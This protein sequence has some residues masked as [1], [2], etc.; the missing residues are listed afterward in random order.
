MFTR[1]KQLVLLGLLLTVMTLWACG[2][3]RD[4]ERPL[5]VTTTTYVGD[6]VRQIGGPYIEVIT[7]IGPG[8]DPHDYQPRQS[9]TKWL[10][11]ADLVV[12]NGLNLEERFGEVL[13]NLDSRSLLV[14]GDHV[15]T[16]QLLFE[17]PNV[18]DPH[19][20]FDPAIWMALAPVVRDALIAIDPANQAAYTARTLQYQRDIEVFVHYAMQQVETVPS[21]RRILVTAH[22]AFAYFGRAFGFE[23]YAVQGIS[24]SGEASIVD[25]EN[26]ARLL[27]ELDIPAL[28]VET[29]VPEATIQAVVE[30]AAALN[31]TV[32]VGGTLYSDSAGVI[33]SGTDTYLRAYRH[34][35]TTIIQA[36]Q[37][38]D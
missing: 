34:N 6:L 15:K 36:L 20:W 27:A 26:L 12:I 7:L 21:S 37:S 24:T 3:D 9:D 19:I 1:R 29:T 14:L 22:D 38:H 25:I 4:D 17:A 28:F 11:D 16:E 18:P 13:R 10:L 30:A 32:V 33:A 31:H 35:I 2:T 8:I 23:V 5:V